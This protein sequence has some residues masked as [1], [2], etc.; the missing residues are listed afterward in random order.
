MDGL[1]PIISLKVLIGHSLS[2]FLW[3]KLGLESSICY[4]CFS[5]QLNWFWNWS[6]FCWM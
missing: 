6:N 3:I 5:Y 4:S 1:P 2:G